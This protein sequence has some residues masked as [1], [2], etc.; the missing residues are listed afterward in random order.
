M[1]RP[2]PPPIPRSGGRLALGLALALGVG[3]ACAQTTPGPAAPSSA[4]P[5]TLTLEGALARLAQAPGVTQA[6]LSVQVAGQNLDAARRALGLSVSVTGSTSYAGGSTATADDGTTTS[7]AGSLGG[8][9]GVQASLGLLPWSS[10]QNSLRTAQR[11][12]TLA[13]ASLQAA[14]ASARL[15][16]Y[17]QYLAAVVAGRDVTLAQDTLALRQR[18]LEIARTQRAQ[19]NATQESV[20]SAQANVQ[21]A[22]ASLLEAR[23]DLEVARLNLAAVLGQSLTGVTFSTQPAGAFTLPDLNTLVTRART[24][25]VDVI[26]AQNTLAAAQE[27]LE[28]QQRDQRL[29]DLTASLR[30]GP[31][32]SGGLS[33]TLDVQAGNAGVGYSVPFGGSGAGNRVVASVTGSYVVYSPALRAQLSAAQA[34][35]TQAQLSVQVAQQNAELS[36]RTLYSTAQTNLTALGSGAT[37]VQVAQATLSAAQARLRAGTGTADAVTSAQIALDQAGR[38]LVQARVTVQLDLIRLQNAAGGAP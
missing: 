24:N 36:V 17:Q 31:A 29:P 19:N 7:T 32:T 8:S 3:G 21:L 27:T 4:N 35:V 26:E 6:Q 11:S 25:T 13:Q 5:S 34:N 33:A 15:N 30:Y 1:T 20:L 12:L 16:V 10:G 23:S 9:V 22:Q 37:Q 2:S 28:E 18:Q 38:N 14:Q